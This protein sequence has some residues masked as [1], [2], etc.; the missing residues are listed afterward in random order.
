MP[1]ETV[2]HPFRLLAFTLV[3]IMIV[4]LVIGIL[5]AIAIPNFLLARETSRA[6]ACIENLKEIDTAKEQWMIDNK[7][8]TFTSFQIIP[9]AAGSPS[10]GVLSTYLRNIPQCPESGY[11]TVGNESELPICYNN[12]SGTVVT[13]STNAVPTPHEIS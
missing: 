4:V 13:G 10:D 9:A 8:S 6:K 11:Y 1:R 3:E 2:Q 7:S 12:S 5:L